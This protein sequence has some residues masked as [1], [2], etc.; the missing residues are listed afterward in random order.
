MNDNFVN[1]LP[2]EQQTDDATAYL[3]VYVVQHLLNL[4]GHYGLTEDGI[5][6]PN[7]QDAVSQFQQSWNKKQPEQPISVDGQVGYDTWQAL[8]FSIPAPT[9]AANR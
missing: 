2:L 6:G 9:L 1:D 8:V 5:F 4:I 7:T 3:G